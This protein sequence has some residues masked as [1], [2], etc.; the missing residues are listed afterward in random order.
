MTQDIQLGLFDYA[1]EA[2][3]DAGCMDNESLYRKVA[4]RAGLSCD[5][6]K[7]TAPVGEDGKEYNLFKRK[8]RW[9]QQ[10]LKQLGL[11]ERVGGSRGLW[12]LT[13]AGEK[14]LRRAKPDVALLA[15]ST[16]LGIAIWGSCQR[17]F[18]RLNE[19]IALVVT[20]PPTRF[21][22]PARTAT[23]PSRNTWTSSADRS[24]RSSIT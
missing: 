9:H 22:S 17:V 10:T 3:A 14:K 1:A 23:R 20:S 7:S 13:D 8:L 11:I 4:D 15:F 6:L 18:A 24:S 5:V 2:Y 21:V 12:K 19:P 16:D